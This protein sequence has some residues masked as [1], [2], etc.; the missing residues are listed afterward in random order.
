MRWNRKFYRLVLCRKKHQIA[1]NAIPQ[2]D[3]F[4]ENGFTYE[5]MK[6]INET[7]KNYGRRIA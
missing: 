2:I 3:K 1:F 5:E 6:M 7:K 4:V